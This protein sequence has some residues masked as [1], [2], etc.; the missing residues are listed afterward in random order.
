M[1]KLVPGRVSGRWLASLSIVVVAVGIGLV[2]TWARSRSDLLLRSTS[3]YKSGD[4]VR[5]ADLARARLKIAPNDLEALRILARATARLGRDGPA[6]ALFARLGSAALEPEDLYLLGLG[7]NRSGEVDKAERVWQRAIAKDSEH[8]ETIEQLIRVYAVRNRLGE[9][10]L[11]AER[12]AKQPGWEMRGELALGSLRSELDD[13]IGA[14]TALRR[15]LARPEASRLEP[16]LESR[17]RKTLVR[18]LLRTGNLGDARA[19]LK[20]LLDREGDAEASWLLSRIALASGDAGEATRA[21]DA[22]GSYRKLHPLESEPCAYV[23]EAR[24]AV[25][26]A[27]VFDALQSSRHSSTLMRNKELAEL[28]YPDHPVPDPD[29]PTV[30]HVFRKEQGQIRFETHTPSAVLRAIVQYAFGSRDH[31]TS[32]V[33]PDDAGRPHI[34]RLSHFQTDHDSGWVRTTGHSADA[35]GGQDI[36][37]KPL[38]VVDGIHRCLFCHS[39]NPGSVL[40]ASGAESADRG[41]GCERCHGPGALHVKALE[42]KFRDRAI[43][44]P[45]RADAEGRLRLCGQCHA[46]HA[47]SPL[48]RTDT[49][50]IRF[51]ATSLPWSRCYTESGGALDCTTCHDPHGN[52]KFKPTDSTARCLKCH[53]AA[54]AP[55]AAKVDLTAGARAPERGAPCPVNPR[56]GCVGCHMPPFRSEPLH[57]TFTDHYI[58][59]HHEMKDRA[60]Q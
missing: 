45:R 51:Q 50:W 9:A 31:Y 25:C 27:E 44:N 40:G 49:F 22:A 7:L 54:A 55:P 2:G 35:E 57:A 29:D 58:R 32:L 42:L 41:I 56:S 39:T 21:L 59:V 1:T 38:D 33:G 11:L 43:A 19:A 18:S 14:A 15:A 53:S 26:H 16:S 28:P 8:A 30:T 24:C 60:R 36:L 17:H 47:E 52:D 13:P 4:W 37:G 34:L 46:Y 3:A 12:L 6:N 10:A 20:P 5:A 23:G 48:P